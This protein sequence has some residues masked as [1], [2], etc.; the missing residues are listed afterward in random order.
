MS[1][2]FLRSVMAVNLQRHTVFH[3]IFNRVNIE[4]QN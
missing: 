4:K 2:A 3:L 1:S